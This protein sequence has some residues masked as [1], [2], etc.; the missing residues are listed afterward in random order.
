M[1]RNGQDLNPSLLIAIL[2]FY[3]CTTGH[4]TDKG[5]HKDC[6]ALGYT[7]GS[8]GTPSRTIYQWKRLPTPPSSLLELRP[9]SNHSYVGV[10]PMLTGD[11]Q[12][13]R[14]S[15]AWVRSVGASSFTCWTKARKDEIRGPELEAEP[16]GCRSSVQPLHHRTRACT[17]HSVK[18]CIKM[19]WN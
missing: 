8:I 10:R 13:L 3:H 19:W 9:C 11:R 15:E 2:L 4:G 12:I 1:P 7:G 16:P 17:H 18:H 14:R 5:T 6:Q